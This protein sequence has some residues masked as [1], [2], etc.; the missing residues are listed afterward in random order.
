MIPKVIHYCWFGKGPKNAVIQSC[1]TSWKR[2]LPDYKI[3]EWNEENYPIT[4][5]NAFAARMYAEKK[6]AFV[7]D[8]ARLDILAREG[9]IYLDTDM[10]LVKSLNDFLSNACF[11]GMEDGTHVS[12]GIIGAEAGHPYILAAKKIYDENPGAIVP[13]PKMLTRVHAERP[14]LGIKLYPPELFYPFTA[15]TIGMFDPMRPPRDAYAIHMWNYAW[16]SPMNK[17]FK[18][19]GIHRA[20]V[21]I[22]DALGLKNM[23]KKILRM[24]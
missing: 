23:F 12:A 16:G 24:P 20:G 18:K 6:W 10:Y 21:R 2:L 7:S 8:Y 17:F 5:E 11:L 1:I 9:G 14:E 4:P 19:I 15:A 22:L 13:I 3:I